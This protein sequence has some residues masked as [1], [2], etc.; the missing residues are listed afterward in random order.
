MGVAERI[1]RDAGG[2]IEI[3]L[4]IRRDQPNAF[5]PLKSEIGSGIGRQKM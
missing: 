2:E 3:A 4:P 1:D 5:A